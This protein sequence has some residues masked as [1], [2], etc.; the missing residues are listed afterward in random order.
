MKENIELKIKFGVKLFFKVCRVWD[1][2]SLNLRSEFIG[3]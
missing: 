2:V 1:G 3:V